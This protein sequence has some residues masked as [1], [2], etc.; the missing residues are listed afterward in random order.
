MLAGLRYLKTRQLRDGSI[1]RAHRDPKFGDVEIG[2]TGLALLAFLGAGALHNESGEF[3]DTVRRGLEFLAS[4]Q[5]RDTGHFGNCSSY[6]HAI[7]TYAFAEAYAMTGAPDLKAPLLRGIRRIIAAQT[8]R[9]GHV[10]DGGFGYYY[11]EPD[12]TYDPWPRMSITVWQVMALESARIGGLHVPGETLAKAKAFVENSHDPRRKAIR[13][14]HDPSWLRSTYDILPGS[15]SAGLF[16]M[17]LLGVD[18]T[19]AAFRDALEFVRARPPRGP[20]RRPSTNDLVFRGLGNEYYLYYATLAL[21]LLGGSDWAAWNSALKPLLLDSQDRDGSWRPISNYADYA[22]DSERDRVY[23]TAMCVLML[24]AYYRYD[25]PLLKQL[26]GAIESGPAP[27]AAPAGIFV[28]SVD[29]GG[30]AEHMGIAPGDRI[31][32]IGGVAVSTMEEVL[33]AL[34]TQPRE[35][36]APATL[37]LV[38]NGDMLVLPL[39]RPLSG[40]DIEVR[41]P[42]EDSVRKPGI[43]G[44]G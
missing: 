27:A 43:S 32:A 17:Q 41:A 10:T 8:D 6:G 11:R 14:N 38:R 22:K 25:T 16:A 33:Q 23:T 35:A 5:D 36:A 34:N 42:Y 9:P 20:W 15:V 31:A 12:R 39:S 1:G 44:G 24:E 18:E 19:G 26:S 4:S 13:Y 30:N 37:T 7:A 21:R 2:K 29:P 3:Q 28:H 40:L